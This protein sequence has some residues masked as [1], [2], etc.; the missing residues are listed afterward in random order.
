LGRYFLTVTGGCATVGTLN[1]AG[2]PLPSRGATDKRNRIESFIRSKD[3]SILSEVHQKDETQR[4]SL[5]QH[6][7]QRLPLYHHYLAAP[8]PTQ[9]HQ[10]DMEVVKASGV[11]ISMSKHLAPDGAEVKAAWDDGSLLHLFIPTLQTHVVGIYAPASAERR[12]KWYPLFSAYITTVRNGLPR[13][14]ELMCMGDWNLPLQLGLDTSHDRTPEPVRDTFRLLLQRLHLHDPWR[15]RHPRLAEGT[16]PYSNA[17][18]EQRWSRLDYALLTPALFHS[19]RNWQHRPTDGFQHAALTGILEASHTSNQGRGVWRVKDAVLR[20][21]PD[22]LRMIRARLAHHTRSL[23]L[24]PAQAHATWEALVID[25]KRLCATAQAAAAKQRREQH[26]LLTQA[27]VAL[28]EL[29]LLVSREAE[30]KQHNPVF[31]SALHQLRSTAH[32]HYLFSRSHMFLDLPQWRTSDSHT[33]AAVLRKDIPQIR[34]HLLTALAENE[35]AGRVVKEGEIGLSAELWQDQSYSNFFR[36]NTERQQQKHYVQEMRRNAASAPTSTP[37]EMLNTMSSYWTEEIWCDPATTPLTQDQRAKWLFFLSARQRKAVERATPML[38][39]D[40]SVLECLKA[41]KALKRH[42]APGTDGLTAYLIQSNYTAWA[43]FLAPFYRICLDRGVM[44]P[45]LTST[46]ITSIFKGPP[47]DMDETMAR[48]LPEYYRPLSMPTTCYKVYALVLLQRLKGVVDAIVHPCQ[49]GFMPR[50]D[51]S[52]SV[53]TLWLFMRETDWPD[54]GESGFV[55]MQDY[56]KAYERVHH[57]WLD[58][59]LRDGYGF[60]PEFCRMLSLCYRGTLVRFLLNGHL[61]DPVLQQRGLKEG[62]PLSP[63]LFVLCLEPLLVRIRRSIPGL[64]PLIGLV[65]FADDVNLMLANAEQLQCHLDLVAEFTGVSGLDLNAAK[66]V[67]VPRSVTQVTRPP[68]LPARMRFL[69]SQQVAQGAAPAKTLGLQIIPGMQADLTTAPLITKIERS[70]YFALPRGY[71]A[72]E[73]GLHQRARML[74]QP[75]Y[76]SRF[77]RPSEAVIQKLQACSR[78]LLYGM[79]PIK[80]KP[81]TFRSGML[82]WERALLKVKHSGYGFV[83]PAETLVSLCATLIPAWHAALAT[84]CVERADWQQLYARQHRLWRLRQWQL[85]MQV[86]ATTWLHNSPFF[87]FLP[88]Q[89]EQLLKVWFTVG[90]PEEILSWLMDRDHGVAL[91]ESYC[92]RALRV[93]QSTENPPLPPAQPLSDVEAGVPEPEQLRP[94]DLAACAIRPRHISALYYAQRL[95]RVCRQDWNSARGPVIR[96]PHLNLYCIRSCYLSARERTHWTDRRNGSIIIE[97]Q[98]RHFAGGQGLCPHGCGEK[99]DWA[100]YTWGCPVLQI[101]LRVVAALLCTAPITAQEWNQ[102]QPAELDQ[103]DLS[104]EPWRVGLARL[105][106]VWH[107]VRSHPDASPHARVRHAVEKWAHSLQKLHTHANQLRRRRKIPKA[108]HQQSWRGYSAILALNNFHNPAPHRRLHRAIN[109]ALTRSAL[110]PPLLASSLIL[111]PSALS[112]PANRHTTQQDQHSS[113]NTAAPRAQSNIPTQPTQ[114]TQLT[115]LQRQ[116]KQHHSMPP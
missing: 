105:T 35:L 86:D 4:Q 96:A 83:E 101:L 98:R 55:F 24:Y 54:T 3:I 85:W 43:H 52:T 12:Q 75:V 84:P 104:S 61:S 62:C 38:R 51:I 34:D 93:L 68:Q 16:Y 17:Q 91:P 99:E 58:T 14:V 57:L 74:A 94:H 70:L 49:T 48:S 77:R 67:L 87:T 37:E 108:Q 46:V 64:R 60:P 21:S 28:E 5:L 71:M 111:S 66:C 69:S 89:E 7:N 79:D 88:T 20:D 25:I 33:V 15:E 106:Y 6:L 100:H 42:S 95:S 72:T 44:P 45:T 115:Q 97:A 103:R 41:I 2:F 39:E 63:L 76:E 78:Q 13:G 30:T 73:K 36:T 81:R 116:D 40:I 59:V 107:A 23:A 8:S 56:R 29:A 11:L 92:A 102:S 112:A 26:A 65:A 32:G 114:A 50:R 31:L 47:A 22:V 9:R 27:V 113:L 80:H 10:Q 82:N 109:H 18:G 1:I 110:F 19:S 53:S 90:K